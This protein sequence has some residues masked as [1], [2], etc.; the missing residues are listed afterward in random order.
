MEM[1]K[2]KNFKFFMETIKALARA[3][4]FYGRILR[5]YEMEDGLI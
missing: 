1:Y 3:Q 2:E 5:V 4:G